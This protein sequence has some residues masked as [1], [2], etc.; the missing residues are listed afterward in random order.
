MEEL[1]ASQTKRISFLNR[2]QQVEGEVISVTDKEVVLD[3]GYKSEGVLPKKDLPKTEEINLGDKI[4]AFVQFPENEN[5]QVVLSSQQQTKLGFKVMSG[6]WQKFSQAQ[7]QKSKLRGRV[8][9]VNKGGLIVEVDSVRGF[10]P[11]SQVGF[12]L[13]NKAGEGP[14]RQSGSEASMENLIGQDLTVT[15]IEVDQSNNKLIFTQRGQ[16]SDELKVKLQGMKIGQKEKG[17]IVAVLPFGLVV[18]VSGMEG[19]VFISDVSWEKVEDLQT[20]FTKSQ[21]IEVLVTGLD[22]EFGRLNL[23]IKR[24]TEDPFEKEASKFTPDEVIKG[25]VVEIS[26]A[27]V[28]FKLSGGVEGFLPSSKISPNASFEKG[29]TVTM[30]VDAVDKARRRVNLA[31]FVTTTAGL[32]YK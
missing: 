4:K 26:D 27:G 22:E 12:E 13:M 1:L 29:K 28:F 32:I 5:G 2:G 23:S 31:P 21:E 16:I 11:N 25:E 15:V 9:E 8:I 6:N 18:D 19:L 17:K 20:K 10:L 14:L 30:L 7:S 3:L 24:L